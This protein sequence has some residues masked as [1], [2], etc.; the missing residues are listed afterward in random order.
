MK[1]RGLAVF[2]LAAMITLATAGISAMAAEGWVQ[3]SGG[4][5]YYNASGNK[6]YNV[7]RQ[8]ADNY[9]RYIDGNGYMTTNSWVDNDN[10]Y[11][12]NNGIMV[13][14]K[15]LQV[16][17][18]TNSA[19]GYDWYYFSSTGK[20]VKS[21]WEKVGDKW[22]NFDDTGAMQTGWVLDDMYYC[23]ANG[24]MQTGWQKL[25]PPGETE[26]DDYRTVPF[27]DEYDDGK[28]WY[29]F[30]SNGKKVLP[31]DEGENVKQKKIDGVYYCLAEDGAMQTGW[32]CVTGDD[33]EDIEEYRYVDANGKV[34]VGWYSAEPPENLQNQYNHDVEWFYFSSK[35]IP[36]VGPGKGSATR[37]DLVKI[38][39]NT[40]LFDEKG[41]PLYGL[42]QVYIDSEN[43]Y[44][45]YYFGNRSQSCM[46]TGKQRVDEAGDTVQYY[47]SSTGRGYTGVY[48]GYLYYMGKLQKADSGSKYEVISIPSGSSNKNYVVNTSGK[49]AKSTTVKDSNGTK[50]KTSGSGILVKE[51]GE[52]VEGGTYT[53]PTEPDWDSWNDW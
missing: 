24:A 47:F 37:S 20:A 27:Y 1:K 2:A 53:N 21:K 34:R 50:Y 51:D 13:S 15:W 29:Y 9:W 23:D 43:E 35:G 44:T 28:K 19:S 5:A 7:W 31:S 33:S 25:T 6:Q 48:D 26:E 14:G 12:D 45:A 32:V 49:V 18:T 8:G 41:V 11:V 38:N 42:Q 16:A 3:E 46:L 30:S 39:G 40:Y 17:T 36:K 10:Y 52:E 22:Y 4:W